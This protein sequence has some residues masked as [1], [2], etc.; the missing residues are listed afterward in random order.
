MFTHLSCNLTIQALLDTSFYLSLQYSCVNQHKLCFWPMIKIE[1]LFL[2]RLWLVRCYER[3]NCARLGETTLFTVNYT[4]NTQQGKCFV[5]P[6]VKKIPLT[7]LL[8]G[9]ESVWTYKKLWYEEILTT[10]GI[11]WALFTTAE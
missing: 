11:H 1:S 5:G 6:S 3:R 9:L 10:L 8:N 7:R 2:S 4:W